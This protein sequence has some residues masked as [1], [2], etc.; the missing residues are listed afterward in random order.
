MKRSVVL[1][2]AIGALL[3]VLAAPSQAAPSPIHTPTHTPARTPAEAPARAQGSAW[4]CDLDVFA[5]RSTGQLTLRHLRNTRVTVSKTTTRPVSWRPVSSIRLSSNET[6][7][8]EVSTWAVAATDG[9]IREVRTE[10]TTASSRLDLRVVRVLGRGFPSRLTA[11]VDLSV[12]WITDDGRLRRADLNGRRTRFGAP[13]TLPVRPSRP[14][15]MGGAASSRG[16]RVYYADRS[17]ALHVV[18]DNPGAA[19]ITRLTGARSRGFSAIKATTCSAVDYSYEPRF[20]ALYTFDAGRGVAGM[21]RNLSFA[22]GTGGAFGS[23]TS[24][25]RVSGTWSSRYLG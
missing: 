12:Y 8:R 6:P 13:V 23:L 3:P 10:W 25:A 9:V 20:G 14:S 17:G 11:L 2:V 7:T 18:A 5:R 24:P 19:T 4:E 15:V 22:S 1:G 16:N 21:R